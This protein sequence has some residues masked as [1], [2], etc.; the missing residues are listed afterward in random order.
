MLHTMCRS[1]THSSQA[2][3][4]RAPHR[5]PR[6]HVC[7][8]APKETGHSHG[9]ESPGT[10]RDTPVTLSGGKAFLRDLAA[11]DAAKRGKE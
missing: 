10:G 1:K 11:A 3:E 5:D 7:V 2:R 4:R 9:R 6:V 8:P